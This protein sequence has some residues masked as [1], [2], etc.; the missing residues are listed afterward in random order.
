MLNLVERL[1]FFVVLPQ[2][3][4][5]EP[6]VN[7]DCVSVVQDLVDNVVIGNRYGLEIRDDESDAEEVQVVA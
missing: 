4:L 7:A 1:H 2:D 3:D 6:S 5:L